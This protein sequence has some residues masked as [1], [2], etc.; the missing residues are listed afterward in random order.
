VSGLRK[1]NVGF[2]L[3]SFVKVR[4]V[5]FMNISLLRA[6]LMHADR[7]TD[8]QT[9]THKNGHDEDNRRFSGVSEALWDR[10]ICLHNWTI[11]TVADLVATPFC[12]MFQ[13]RE[14]LF[15]NALRIVGQWIRRI[16]WKI[17]ILE[18]MWNETI[19]AHLR[20][21]DW[22]TMGLSPYGTGAPRPYRQALSVTYSDINSGEPCPFTKVPDGHQT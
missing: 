14:W 16:R 20:M 1:S 5:K 3:Q 10:I 22:L 2:C 4:N 11:Q 8:R 18:R 13:G 21:I 7:Q 9:D 6:A 12:L 15:N 17:K 19:V